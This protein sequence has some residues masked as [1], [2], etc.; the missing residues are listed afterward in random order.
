MR[1]PIFRTIV[2]G[3]VLGCLVFLTDILVAR[4]P[5]STRG[6]FR[7]DAPAAPQTLET[8]AS[9]PGWARTVQVSLGG[10][11]CAYNQGHAVQPTSDG[12]LVVAGIGGFDQASWEG[13]DLAVMKL[14]PS[15]KVAWQLGYD[16]LTGETY[17]VGRSMVRTTDGEYLVAGWT[18]EAY[19]MF[20]DA[21]A[22][23]LAGNGQVKWLK[24]YGGG[25]N[26]HAYS[27]QA[28]GDGGCILAGNT[29]SFSS[30][31]T[32]AWI[33]KLNALGN[34]VWQKAIGG[35][36]NECLYSIHGMPD[37]G[38]IAVGAIQNWPT[39]QAWVIRFGHNG[40]VKWQKVYGDASSS[41]DEARS[42]CPT[43]DGGYLV[44]GSK[45]ARDPN[46]SGLL[47]SDIW[48][49]KLDRSGNI[50]WQKAYRGNAVSQGTMVL[51][52]RGGGF[53]VIGSNLALNI[54]PTG[55]LLWQKIFGEQTGGGCWFDGA[56]QGDNGNFVMTGGM[57]KSMLVVSLNPS[58]RGGS[59][60][61][62]IQ[63]ASVIMSETSALPTATS[64][65]SRFTSAI[66]TKIVYH[67]FIMS[68]Q[69]GTVCDFLP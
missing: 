24:T 20:G 48:V 13:E 4:D 53:L 64:F 49:W 38:Y 8:A 60:C 55:D 44:A 31:G 10:N 28:T 7:A 58:G 6:R 40:F 21:F 57:A 61:P 26:D 35:P 67:P 69:V 45:G 36:A 39:S 22:M 15:G 47:W 1:K 62:L 42:I 11:D 9:A 12:G 68:S 46:G 29:E 23:K 34:I 33:L 52:A 37:G 30:V 2:L 66:A 17:N 32:D 41:W 27:V 51:P 54:G 59:S 3:L 65:S 43:G 56:F 18:G 16:P 63:D 25:A 19:D 14:R 50:I 5:S